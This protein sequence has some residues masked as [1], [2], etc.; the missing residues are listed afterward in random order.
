MYASIYFISVKVRQFLFKITVVALFY[1]VKMTIV[2]TSYSYFPY[3]V[4]FFSQYAKN[5][6]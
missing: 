4:E 5:E 1:D 3:K 6:N 2:I